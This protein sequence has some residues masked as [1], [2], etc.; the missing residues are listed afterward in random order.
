MLLESDFKSGLN[1]Y[2]SSMGCGYIHNPALHYACTGLSICKT[3]GL[4]LNK[5]KNN[6]GKNYVEF[7]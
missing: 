6:S 3:Y 5:I 1:S 2:W 4:A 7:V